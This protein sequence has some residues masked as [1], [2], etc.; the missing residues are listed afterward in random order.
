MR[1][2][3]LAC[4][5]L[6][7]ASSG[8]LAAPAPSAGDEQ[9][10]EA[11]WYGPGFDGRRTANGERFDASGLSAAHAAWPLP[12]LVRVTNLANGRAVTVRVNDRPGRGGR[13]II[14]LS[15]G[16]AEALD[17]VQVGRARV[18]VRYLG[19]APTQLN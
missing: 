3:W 1:A 15:R 11:T 10:G 18:T 12:C 16:A 4:A 9:T 14:D 13:Q 17:I 19:P 8:A 7:V 5:F 6:L 2:L